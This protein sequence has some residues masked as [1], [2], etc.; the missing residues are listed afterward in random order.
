MLEFRVS[1][2]DEARY[3]DAC[4]NNEYSEVSRLATGIKQ[5]AFYLTLD[6]ED[7]ARSQGQPFTNREF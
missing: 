4:F 5:D 1:A 6:R 7:F 2:A 3:G